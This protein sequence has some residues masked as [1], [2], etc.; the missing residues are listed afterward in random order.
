M[1]GGSCLM[2]AEY[3]DGR[4]RAHTYCFPDGFEPQSAKDLNK[5]KEMI[6]Q[7]VQAGLK[8]KPQDPSPDPAAGYSRKGEVSIIF[9]FAYYKQITK[10]GNE[11]VSKIET[12][13]GVFKVLSV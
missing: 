4:G 8:T 9:K 3:I 6:Q 7:A 10:H 12:V 13:I 5:M 1:T 2:K 11:C